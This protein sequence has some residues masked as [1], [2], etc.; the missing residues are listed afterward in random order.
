MKTNDQRSIIMMLTTLLF[1]QC[2]S[3]I[4]CWNSSLQHHSRIHHGRNQWK[5]HH[6]NPAFGST[7]VSRGISTSRDTNTNTSTSLK[8]GNNNESQQENE[9]S[10]FLEPKLTEERMKSLFAWVSRAFAG[11]EDY[12][13][14]MLAMA[15]IFGT[16][17]PPQ[18]LPLQLVQKGESKVMMTR[19]YI[20][21]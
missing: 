21:L 4:S 12:N 1:F 16:N 5:F 18:S 9:L 14:L 2:I 15:A 7:C 10:V 17:L 6:S 8:S 19:F 3:F 11:D 20:H 13:N